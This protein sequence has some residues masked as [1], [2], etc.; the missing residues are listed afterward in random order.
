MAAISLAI[1]ESMSWGDG[2]DD[3]DSNTGA[4]TGVEAP[5]AIKKLFEERQS[6]KSAS[7]PGGDQPPLPLKMLLRHP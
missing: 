1:K 5:W 6:K 2:L 7:S 3:D 4:S